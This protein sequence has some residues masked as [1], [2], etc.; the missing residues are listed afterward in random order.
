MGFHHMQS[1]YNRDEFVRIAWENIQP[2]KE[3]NF[4]LYGTDRVTHFGVDYDLDSVMHYGPTGF[5]INGQPTIVPLHP[6]GGIVMGQRTHMS[7]S[8]QLRIKRMYGCAPV[9]HEA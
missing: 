7:E 4:A 6:L 2:G 3:N 8:D 1:S 5:S 9:P